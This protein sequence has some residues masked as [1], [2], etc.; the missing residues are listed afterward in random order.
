MKRDFKIKFKDCTYFCCIILIALTNDEKFFK[1]TSHMYK[2][3][4]LYLFCR[5]IHMLC[6]L[7]PSR[8]RFTITSFSF[9][10]QFVRCTILLL[11]LSE[12]WWLS[13]CTKHNIWPIRM[14]DTTAALQITDM[15]STPMVRART[16]AL[17]TSSSKLISVKLRIIVYMF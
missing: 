4:L 9:V 13:V 3:S 17:A 2:C 15:W 11:A 12:W 6:M 14:H 5:Y 10:I 1:M 8:A 16:L 7:S